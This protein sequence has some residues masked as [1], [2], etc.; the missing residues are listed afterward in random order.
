MLSAKQVLDRY[1]LDVRCMMIEIGAMLDRH[2]RG[3]DS[4]SN[5]QAVDGRLKRIFDALELL[6]DRHATPDRSERLLKLFTEE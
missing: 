3:A 5:G 2:D 4:K 6:A 1:Y